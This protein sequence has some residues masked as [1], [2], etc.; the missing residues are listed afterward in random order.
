ML[1]IY[2]RCLFLEESA[3][4]VPKRDESSPGLI[5]PGGICAA[6]TVSG[7]I[8]PAVSATVTVESDAGLLPLPHAAKNSTATPASMNMFVTFFI[9]PLFKGEV[10][11]VSSGNKA[12]P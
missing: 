2:R 7:F 1:R 6:G 10:N 9:I 4:P 12:T 3:A 11:Q 8:S 5:A